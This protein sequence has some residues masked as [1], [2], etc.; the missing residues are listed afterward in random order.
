M[1]G[2]ELAKSRPSR[3]RSWL[4]RWMWP[5]AGAVCVVLILAALVL[6]AAL[7]SEFQRNVLANFAADLAV[8]GLAFVVANI[9][10]GFTERRKREREAVNVATVLLGWELYT[11][12]ME[13][14]RIAAELQCGNLDL[15]DR[16]FQPDSTLQTESWHLLIQSPLAAQLPSDLVWHLHEAY[17]TSE[18][19][20]RQLKR[21]ALRVG[22][23]EEERSKLAQQFAWQ[24]KRAHALVKK[25]MDQLGWAAEG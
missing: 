13:V 18:A 23:S 6:G 10:F 17:Y 8:A 4:T 9:A 22:V 21:R 25:A 19:L 2:K 5:V 24:F 3:A 12:S 15:S 14:Q 1:T 11:N 20:R 7:Q 16:F